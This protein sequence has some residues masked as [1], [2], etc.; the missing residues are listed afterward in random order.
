MCGQW[1]SRGSYFG[2]EKA[3]QQSVLG[4]DTIERVLDELAP[5]GLRLVDMVGGETLLYPAFGE[6]LQVFARRGIYA[7]FA[8]NG[9]LLDRFARQ[10]VESRVASVTVSVDGDR[11]THNRIRG[12]DWAYDRCLG[13]LRALRSARANHGAPLVQ[14]AYTAS[15]HNGAAPLI[16]LCED[17]RGKGL[18]DVVEIKTTPIFVPERAARSYIDMARRYFG[19]EGGIMSPWSFLDDYGDFGEEALALARTIRLL[20]SRRFDFFVEALPHIPP[21]QIPRLFSDYEW[22][23]GRSPCPV[24]Y[25]EPTIDADGNVYPCNVFT[26]ES[27]S[28]GNIHRSS[29]EEIWRGERFMRFRQM[30][31]DNGG[32]LPICTRCCQ[33][34]EY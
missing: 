6:L 4:P 12:E 21:E 34:T 14:L 22:D 31:A 7:K 8:T 20:K 1:G 11:N 16:A 30:L 32:L 25:T 27:L 28:M 26:D 24:P 9:T 33:L 3:R 18:V 13:G 2:Y 29:F 23:L 5:R 15:R 10:V 19:V 17:L